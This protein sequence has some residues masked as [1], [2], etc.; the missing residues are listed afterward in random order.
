MTI[1]IH[2]SG[3]FSL[4]TATDTQGTYGSG[5]KVDSGKIMGSWRARQR[6]AI[7]IAGAG[8]SSYI[9]ALSEEIDRE[10]HKFEGTIEDLEAKVREVSGEFYRD[11]VFPY[12]GKRNPL[13]AN[14]SRRDPHLR[15]TAPRKNER[16]T[17][18]WVE[19]DVGLF[20]HH[21]TN[22]ISILMYSKQEGD[23]LLLM[24][25]YFV[26][27]WHTSSGIGDSSV[28]NG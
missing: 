3:H 5:D 7:N 22:Y 19:V 15:S 2:L 21:D 14:R 27:L 26:I 23:I 12:E 10:F 6:G 13:R 4:I 11:N 9:T 18:L 24:Y 20:F 1:A 17:S 16:P 8:D 28:L 25:A